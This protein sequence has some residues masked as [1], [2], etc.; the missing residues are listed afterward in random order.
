MKS[1]PAKSAYIV[2]EMTLVMPWEKD[3]DLQ[4]LTVK[5]LALIIKEMTLVMPWKKDLDL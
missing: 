2:R 1:Y 5:I 4:N 3:L